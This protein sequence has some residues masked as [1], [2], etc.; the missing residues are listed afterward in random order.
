ML[1]SY[2]PLSSLNHTTC[3]LFEENSYRDIF[4]KALQ[5]FIDPTSYLFSMQI[6]SLLALT[7]LRMQVMKKHKESNT[8]FLETFEKF[9]D[10][11]I[12]FNSAPEFSVIDLKGIASEIEYV[13]LTFIPQNQIN[14]ERLEQFPTLILQVSEGLIFI[15]IPKNIR[16]LQKILEKHLIF[17]AS[18]CNHKINALPQTEEIMVPT[19]L[20]QSI[21]Q[22]DNKEEENDEIPDNRMKKMGLSDQKQNFMVSGNLGMGMAMPEE[23]FFTS[24]G[25]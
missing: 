7:E 9:I 19:E 24:P 18:S 2:N 5:K 22:F 23:E 8:R 4:N 16:I 10:Y 20:V 15:N 6:I 17:Q 14:L 11:E 13:A 12:V 1:F 3:S 25:D 21:E